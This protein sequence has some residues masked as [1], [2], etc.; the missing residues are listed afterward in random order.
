MKN[1]IV[2]VVSGS[3]D[4]LL[5]VYGNKKQAYKCALKYVQDGNWRG[6]DLGIISYSKVCKELKGVYNY[7]VELIE[8][9]SDYNATIS[10][11]LFNEKI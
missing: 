4:G 11:V 7:S 6:N 10:A 1:K 2:F 5:G 9:Y 8:S 3:E